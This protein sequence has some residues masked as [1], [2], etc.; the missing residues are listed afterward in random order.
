MFRERQGVLDAYVR[1]DSRGWGMMG[2][3]EMRT[4]WFFQGPA[5]KIIFRA[6]VLFCF[7]FPESTWEPWTIL[8]KRGND[9]L[10]FRNHYS[11]SVCRLDRNKV[12]VVEAIEPNIL[13]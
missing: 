11:G 8:R 9:W 3:K 1:V 7:V 10:P 4:K 6:P 5:M 13:P 2:K 12:T